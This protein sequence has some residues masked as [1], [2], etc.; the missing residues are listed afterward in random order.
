MLSL[1]ALGIIDPRLCACGEQP[2]GWRRRRRVPLRFKIL[3]NVL[4]RADL[5]EA[6]LFRQGT[7][8]EVICSFMAFLSG[9]SA[10]LVIAWR[11]AV[12]HLCNDA[13]G[14]PPFSHNKR[15]DSGCAAGRIVW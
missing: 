10:A 4:L 2:E 11:Q 6:K 7:Q 13:A 5:R 3:K 15:V 8:G 9:A 12:Q 14:R 1:G